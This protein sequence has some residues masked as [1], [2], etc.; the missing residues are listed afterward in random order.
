MVVSGQNR[1]ARTSAIRLLAVA[2]V[3]VVCAAYAYSPIMGSVAALALIIPVVLGLPRRAGYL[4]GMLVGA[5]LGMAAPIPR[6]ASFW[7]ET[8][9]SEVKQI[10]FVHTVYA[11]VGVV[12]GTLVSLLRRIIRPMYPSKH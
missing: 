8:G 3:A 9:G 11:L 2:L 6:S 5:I 4:V 10:V 1:P 12:I 7:F